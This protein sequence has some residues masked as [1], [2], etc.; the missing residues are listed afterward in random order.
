MFDARMSLNLLQSQWSVR[1]PNL[2]LVE[3]LSIPLTQGVATYNIPS[4]VVTV[5]DAYVRLFQVGNAVNIPVSFTT[6]AGST[7]VTINWP[8]HNLFATE[9]INVQVPVSVGGVIIQGF[10]QATSIIDVNNFTITIPSAALTSVNA[11][12]VVPQFTTQMGSATVF[13]SFPNH[14]LTTGQNFTVQIPTSVGGLALSGVYQVQNVVST[15]VF[16]ITAVGLAGSNAVVYE[17][18]GL[19]AYQTQLV[20]VDPNDRVV[21]PI[22]RTDYSAQ[23]DKFTQ[24]FPSTYWFN[25]QINPVITTWPVAD[26][27]GPYVLNVYCVTQPQDATIPGGAT[28]NIPYR[29]L[30]AFAAGLARRLARKYAP[31]LVQEL[32]IEENMVWAEASQEDTETGTALYIAPG[33]GGY[34][35]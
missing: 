33:L 31:Q 1:V 30:E 32:A 16:A 27:N 2:W 35:R 34:F 9:W 4:N 24:A 13:V 22:S 11:G 8:A 18:L 28:L 14:G 19:Q 7:N 6:V 17:N 5:L 29:F 25:R 15:S 26:Q 20:G 23:P 3:L 21:T 12:G 10:F